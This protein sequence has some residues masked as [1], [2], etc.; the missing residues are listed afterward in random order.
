MCFSNAS[1][2]ATGS[3][4]G[5][6]CGYVAQKLTPELWHPIKVTAV[7]DYGTNSHG[8]I[9]PQRK[10]ASLNQISLVNQ[11]SQQ[12]TVDMDAR[13]SWGEYP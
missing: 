8:D 2:S 10:D 12:S 4:H 11:L 3:R 9:Q 7:D 1:L 13:N 5:A 6:L